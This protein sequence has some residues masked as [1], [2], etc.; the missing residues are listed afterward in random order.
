MCVCLYVYMYISCFFFGSFFVSAC[1]VLFRFAHFYFYLILLLSYCY[2]VGFLSRDRNSVD[3]HGREDRQNL[4]GVR[5]A[6]IIV[7]TYYIKTF[8]IKERK[9]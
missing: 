3:S 2:P 5:E 4:R 6:E 9:I 8:T 7:R 1:F